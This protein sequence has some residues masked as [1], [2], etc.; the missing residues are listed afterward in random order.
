METGWEGERWGV[1]GCVH[2]EN[3]GRVRGIL[4]DVVGSVR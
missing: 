4:R 1:F 3:D 2:L